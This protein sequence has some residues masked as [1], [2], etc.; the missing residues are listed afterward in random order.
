MRLPTPDLMA[1]ERARV[2]RLHPEAAQRVTDPTD[3]RFGQLPT[4]R[5]RAQ[6]IV[7]PTDPECGRRSD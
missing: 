4:P 6:R 2:M 7:D 1:G 5:S 3:P